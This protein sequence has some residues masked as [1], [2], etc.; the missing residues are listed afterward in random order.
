MNGR[1]KSKILNNFNQKGYFNQEKLKK[2]VNIEIRYKGYIDRQIED[3]QN[4]EKLE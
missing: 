4:M 2:S 1:K 3:V